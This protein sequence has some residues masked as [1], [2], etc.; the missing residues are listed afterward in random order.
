MIRSNSI[1]HYMST[2]NNCFQRL[3]MKPK[4][5]NFYIL[6]VSSP[7]KQ[8][9]KLPGCCRSMAISFS[10]SA[11]ASR[12]VLDRP[13]IAHFNEVGNVFAICSA[14]RR[15]VN[16]VAPRRTISRSLMDGIMWRL[17]VE[18]LSVKHDSMGLLPRL[19]GKLLY[20]FHPVHLHLILP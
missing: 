3:S 4:L 2:F 18:L 9:A 11:K 17:F 7:C 6:S 20:Y 13:P 19:W 5:D 15:P 12:L 14:I 10:L 1:D 16:P 8:G